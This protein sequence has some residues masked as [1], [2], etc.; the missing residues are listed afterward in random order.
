MNPG[1]VCLQLSQVLLDIQKGTAEDSWAWRWEVTDPDAALNRELLVKEVR[2]VNGERTNG[3]KV[4][5]ERI[6]Q[7]EQAKEF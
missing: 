2:R 4:N 5:G 6:N 7:V 3:E 1:P